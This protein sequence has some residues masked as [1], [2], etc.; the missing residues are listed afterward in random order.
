MEASTLQ[1]T[2][3]LPALA[4]RSPL[5]R[6]QTDERLVALTRRGHHGAFEALWGV[7]DDEEPPESEHRRTSW[8]KLIAAAALEGAIFKAT[9]VATDHGSR[10]AF[11]NVTGSWP[12][13]EE[14]EEK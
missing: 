7:V 3:R 14:P 4:G 5:L 1:H 12:G 8:R 10:Q 2:A 11:A 6:L 13:E 9:R